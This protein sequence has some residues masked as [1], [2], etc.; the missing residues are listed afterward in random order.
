ML[1]TIRVVRSAVHRLSRM[2][3][4]MTIEWRHATHS[5]IDVV[6]VDANKQNNNG[7]Y[8]CPDNLERQIALNG[9]SITHFAGA[10]SEADQAEDQQPH[11]AKKQDRANAEE[12]LEKGV[13]NRCIAA[14]IDGQERHVVAHP[15]TGE[16]K[17]HTQKKGDEGWRDGHGEAR[18]LEAKRVQPMEIPAGV[19]VLIDSEALTA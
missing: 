4:A 10:T 18:G 9:R 16:H 14:G 8:C 6:A 17:G 19:E 5:F 13:V 3:R 11:D 12:N 1:V 2:H 7:W 15:E